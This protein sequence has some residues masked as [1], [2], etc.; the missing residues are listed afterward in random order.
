LTKQKT[1]REYL[2]ELQ[3]SKDEKPSQVKQGLEIYVELWQSALDKGVVE[4]EDEM[5]VALSKIEE[6]GGLYEAA[7]G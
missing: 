3:A 4:P 2:S 7:E 5:D 1:V 6:R